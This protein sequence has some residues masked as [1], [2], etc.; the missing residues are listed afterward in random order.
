MTAAA[1]IG[2]SSVLSSGLSSA[3]AAAEYGSAAYGKL[4]PV[5]IKLTGEAVLAGEAAAEL[6]TDYLDTSEAETKTEALSRISS[7]AENSLRNLYPD[8]EIGYRYNVLINGFSCSLP[9]NLI[10]EARN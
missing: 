4:V 9:E 10:A 6:G 2:V 7:E 8:L 5:I 3:L 1:A